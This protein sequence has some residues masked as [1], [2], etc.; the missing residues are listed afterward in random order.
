[1]TDYS[2]VDTLGVRYK[3]MLTTAA[4]FGEKLL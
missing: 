1:M 2:Q 3:N 4:F